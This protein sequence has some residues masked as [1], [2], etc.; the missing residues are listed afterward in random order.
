MATCDDGM[1]RNPKNGAECCVEDPVGS[2]QCQQEDCKA[3]QII[4]PDDET[5]CCDTDNLFLSIR[6]SKTFFFIFKAQLRRGKSSKRPDL[7]YL[8]PL[9]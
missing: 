6:G 4:N 7:R 2:G 3:P 9:A 5:Q 1:I 8:L